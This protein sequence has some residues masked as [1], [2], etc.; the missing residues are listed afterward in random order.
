MVGYEDQLE[1]IQL[2]AVSEGL[3]EIRLAREE[4]HDLTGEFEEGE[5]WF[6]LRMHMFLDWYLLDRPGPEGLTPAEKFLVENRGRLSQPELMQFTHLTVSLRSVFHIERIGD[7][8]LLLD[9]MAGGGQWSALWMM[10]TEG[11]KQGD[12]IDARIV[13]IGGQPTAGRGT[14]LHP[15]EAREAIERIVERALTKGMHPREIVDHLDKMRLK[16]DRYSNVRIRHVYQY[17]GD[18]LL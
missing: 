6:D 18:A 7:S 1:R 15:R 12:I 17:P 8:E 11:L 2:E 3:T 13:M 10:P 5:P 14:V 9:D 16:L 4:F